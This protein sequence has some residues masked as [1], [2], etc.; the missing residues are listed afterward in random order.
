[1]LITHHAHLRVHRD[2]GTLCLVAAERAADASGFEV[3]LRRLEA[4]AQSADECHD[5]ELVAIVQ[6]SCGKVVVD[7]TPASFAA[8]CTVRVPPRRRICFVNLGAEAMQMVVVCGSAQAPAAAE[9]STA[10]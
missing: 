10:G 2:G 4:G 1:M 6:S 9:V 5:S 7:G 8:P 3:Q